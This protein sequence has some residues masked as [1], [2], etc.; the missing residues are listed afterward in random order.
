[1]GD[2]FAPNFVAVLVTAVAL[3][4]LGR[5]Y[6]RI[7][8][9]WGNVT[10]IGRPQTITLTTERTPWQ[11]LVDGCR[12]LVMLIFLT[13]FFVIP[14]LIGI[15]LL[16]AAYFF[17]WEEVIGFVTSNAQLIIRQFI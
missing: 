4:V 7:R 15:V 1:M 2:G 6:S 16:L 3:I 13:V 5:I 9:Y 8:G 11:I 17:G 12:S 10:A 14:F